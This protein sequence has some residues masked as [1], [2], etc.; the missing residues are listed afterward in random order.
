MNVTD[1]WA[2]IRPLLST[3]PVNLRAE[4]AIIDSHITGSVEEL[5]TKAAPLEQKV[6]T[7]VETFV[8]K[9]ISAV[10]GS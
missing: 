4:I 6:E 5:Q 3:I 2:K 10:K 9:V 8:E 1:A 7:A